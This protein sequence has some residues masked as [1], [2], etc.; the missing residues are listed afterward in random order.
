MLKYVQQWSEKGEVERKWEEVEDTS[1]C[2]FLIASLLMDF[3]LTVVVESCKQQCKLVVE[4]F[5]ELCL[6][7]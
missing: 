6:N 2:Y 7:Y 1:C 5:E 3:K 4:V